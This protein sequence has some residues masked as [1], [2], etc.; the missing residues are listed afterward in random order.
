MNGLSDFFDSVKFELLQID[1]FSL[2]K[3]L[4][5]SGDWERTLVLFQWIVS[6]IGS[7]NVKLDNQVVELMVKI[8]RRESQYTI[9][10]KLFDLVHIEEY[11][12]DVRAYTTILHA[13]SGSDK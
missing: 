5:L 4:D 3:A 7:D 10:L 1:M 13:Y 6:D 2:L 9:A 12:L 8:L 11:S